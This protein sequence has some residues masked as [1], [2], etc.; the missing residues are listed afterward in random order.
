MDFDEGLQQLLVVV[1]KFRAIAAFLICLH[2][3]D[4]A[5]AITTTQFH[6]F[7]LTY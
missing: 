4:T 2:N 1:G 5:T 6:H 3:T 7:Q